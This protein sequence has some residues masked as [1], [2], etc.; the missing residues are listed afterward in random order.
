MN[1]EEAAKLV[2]LVRAVAPAQKIDEFTPDVWAV[3]L[4]DIKLTD[5]TQAVKQLARRQPYIGTSDIVGE[6]KKIR[7]ERLQHIET[8]VTL[9][10][11]LPQAESGADY[12]RARK[13]FVRR[14][15]NGEIPVSLDNLFRDVPQIGVPD[16]LHTRRIKAGREKVNEELR[17][18]RKAEDL[19]RDTA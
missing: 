19:N 3:V 2:R 11:D 1:R 5:A 7:T 10:S 14:M 6:V 4:D 9:H 12:A 16:D 17:R 18:R 15:A 8:A 13:E